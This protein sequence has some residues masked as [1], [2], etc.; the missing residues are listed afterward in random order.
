MEMV[1]DSLIFK[2]FELKVN[3]S[4][5][6]IRH[7]SSVHIIFIGTLPDIVFQAMI[8]FGLSSVCTSW[9]IFFKYLF[10]H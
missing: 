10:L 3:L 5:V 2:Y 8:Y 7:E 6:A 9:L 1:T 4:L